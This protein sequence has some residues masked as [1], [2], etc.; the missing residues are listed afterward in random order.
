M[1]LS[2]AYRYRQ[3]GPRAP[4][5]GADPTPVLGA[6]LEDVRQTLRCPWLDP[7]VEAAAR[8]PVFFTAAWS[9]IRPNVGRSLLT[10]CRSLRTEAANLARA[11]LVPPDL[12]K[13]LEPALGEGELTRVEDCVR[14][15]HLASAKYQV[16]VHALYRAAQRDRVGGTGGEEP[17]A[18]RGVP[19]WQ[20]WMAAS[21]VPEESSAVLEEARVALGLPAP[22][23][24]LRLLARWPP[25]AAELWRELREAWGSEAWEEAAA[26][27]R[28]L[29][30]AGVAT[31]PHPIELQWAALMVRGFTEEDRLRAA[32]VLAAHET[33]MPSQTLASAFAWVSLGAPDVGT[34]A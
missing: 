7:A 12:R 13:R 9:A 4:A 20:R 34:E 31:L 10:L 18:R 19:D 5:P 33:A 24:A 27:L 25:A 29:V 26:R 11:L 30:L 15:L 23:V 32:E 3:E 17:P 28:R 14:A 1:T 16:V 8:F 2:R 22:P 21:V 6:V